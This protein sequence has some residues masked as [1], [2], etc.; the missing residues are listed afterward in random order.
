[1]QDLVIIGAVGFAR[2]VDW[3]VEEINQKAPKWNLIGY[4]DENQEKWGQEL[5]TYPVWGYFAALEK[6]PLSILTI[7]AV[8]NPGDK[9]RLVEKAKVLGTK[10]ATLIHP[11][12]SVY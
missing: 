7:C 4:I 11:A 9:L 3:L 12:I 2:E 5:N 6:L 1:M 10:F 8:G